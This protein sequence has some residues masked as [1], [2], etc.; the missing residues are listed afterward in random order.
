MGGSVNPGHKALLPFAR[1]VDHEGKIWHI[2]CQDECCVHDDEG[3]L[4]MWIIP[5]EQMGDLPSK[6]HGN[7]L[8]TSEADIEEGCGMLSLTGEPGDITK[9]V[10]VNYITKKHAGECVAVPLYSAVDM[11]SGLADG[12][13]CNWTG[14]LALMQ[15]ELFIDIFNVMYNLEAKIP[16]MAKATSLD[17]LAMA[18]TDEEKKAFQHGLCMQI[19]R[20]QGHLKKA[21]DALN[22]NTAPGINKGPGGNQPHYRHT[23]APLPDGHTD[24][25]TCRQALCQSGCG[26]C[27]AAVDRFGHDPEF[28]SVGMKGSQKILTERG[29]WVAGTLGPDAAKQLN[30][31]PDWGSTKSAIAELYEKEYHFILVG[32]A[33]HAELASKEHG[34]RRIKNKVKPY[35]DGT[36]GTLRRLVRDAR[37]TIL[38][39]ARLEDARQCREVMKAYRS[40]A[41]NGELCTFGRLDLWTKK[42]KKRRGVFNTETSA[43]CF[44]MGMG[45][46]RSS[47]EALKRIETRTR[48]DAK[49]AIFFAKAEERWRKLKRH[50]AY[51]RNYT[52]LVKEQTRVRNK[53]FIDA[54]KVELGE[55]FKWRRL[56]KYK[57]QPRQPNQP[58]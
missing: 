26:T 14:A 2:M 22:V 33:C 5:D 40:L 1:S 25:R 34:W 37:K 49:K 58:Q 29:K 15:F 46:S 12:K 39:K 16:D 36:I 13:E 4:W 30:A 6:H 31:E 41:A 10:L 17:I 9:A 53:A 24:W 52:T 7:N 35:V 3:E 19:D 18:I 45:I 47:D 27:Q 20:S 42:H 21:T 44:N 23:F 51:K 55:N 8:H 11:E 56:S 48:N 54:Q 50:D 32:V 43:L 57:R 38:Q 28:Q